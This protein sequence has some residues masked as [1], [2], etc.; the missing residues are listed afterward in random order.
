MYGDEREKES[1]TEGEG[2]RAV[3]GAEMRVQHAAWCVTMA[4]AVSL[5]KITMHTHKYST[6]I[7]EKSS[8]SL[9]I[10][11]SVAFQEYTEVRLIKMNDFV[12]AALKLPEAPAIL[13]C[14]R[15]WRCLSHACTVF[16]MR[17]GLSHGEQ[18]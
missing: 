8:K 13:L 9:Y 1:E 2:E 16:K 3:R 15:T 7:A 5:P 18:D 4:T 11:Q 12:N 17:R 10:Q 14:L 6:P